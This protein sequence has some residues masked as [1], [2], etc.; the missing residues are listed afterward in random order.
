MP[1]QIR[2]LVAD[3]H[4]VV[5]EGLVSLID[6]Q[7]DMKVVAEAGNGREAVELHRSHHPDVTMMDL[8]MPE[9]TGIEAIAA[10]RGET[11]EAR[12]VC[13][14]TFEGDE[15][16]YRALQAGAR[17]YLLKGF[18]RDVLLECIRSVHR[19]DMWIPPAIAGKL[20][21]RVSRPELS[22]REMDVL[23][24]LVRGKANKEI[25]SSLDITEGT[26]K[27]HINHIFMKLGVSGR[28]E[29]ISEALKRGIVNLPE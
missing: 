27:V 6:R 15:D 1:A 10:I 12:I 29:A 17:G 23:G 7:A 3:D 5:R 14:T 20:A 18:S 13:L 9:L 8:R 28:T 26:V 19:G 16:V 22:S 2:V 24:L 4:P 25:A 21:T 11:P